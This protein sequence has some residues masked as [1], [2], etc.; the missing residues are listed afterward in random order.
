MKS[1]DAYSIHPL[2]EETLPAALAL[3]DVALR[4]GHTLEWYRWKHLAPPAGPSWAWV[5]VAG[6]SVIGVRLVM[7]WP[8]LVDGE[9]GVAARMVDTATSPAHRGS[10]V[11]RSLT[12]TALASLRAAAD[13]P[14]FVMNTPNAQSRPGYCRMGW[15]LLPPIPHAYH[16]V[17]PR[18]RG[19][20]VEEN[21]PLE[22]WPQSHQGY[23]IQT[24]RSGRYM[25]WRYQLATLGSYQWL[26]LRESENPNGL[27][28]R[29]R[30]AR[31]ARLLLVME[32]FGSPR[33]RCQL[34]SA[35]A[36][37]E[38]AFMAIAPAGSNSWA[39]RPPSAPLFVRGSSILAVR[40]LNEVGCLMSDP[41]EASSWQLS[42]G[43][44]EDVL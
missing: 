36:R 20:R 18:L 5:A 6:T 21:F 11:F 28:Y 1:T 17:R 34:L 27:V 3:L 29:V 19:P 38:H 25:R 10:G 42:L 24:A 26:R 30:R 22:Q 44:V 12:L 9:W 40:A 4:P 37:R 14:R 32:L 13:Q 43:D 16:L 39:C 15:T 2:S 31:G 33:E 7:R 23:G 8:L 41:L 35:A